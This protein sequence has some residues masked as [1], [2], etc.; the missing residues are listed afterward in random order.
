MGVTMQGLD[1]A[2][3]VRGRFAIPAVSSAVSQ[4]TAGEPKVG[5][6]R[7]RG[8]YMLVVLR[9]VAAGEQLFRLEGRHT[10]TPSRFSVQLGIDSHIDL[11]DDQ[12]EQDILDRYF[13]R[14]LNHSCDPSAV[15]VD[16]YVVAH[17]DLAAFDVVTFDYN[18]TEWDMAEPF[19][20]VCGASNCLSLIRGF[21][22][23]S[24]GQVAALP[25]VAAY[26]EQQRAHLAIA[27]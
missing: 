15:I 3:I 16:P 12:S 18:T 2:V 8:E 24:A 22:H 4:Q 9:P 23:L 6:L 13:W 14:F 11:P 19:A 7:A 17:R 1:N 27:G 26:L 5:V 25:M 20:C 21:R 10:A